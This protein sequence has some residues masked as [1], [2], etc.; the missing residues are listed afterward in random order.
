MKVKEYLAVD[1]AILADG[2]YGGV[3]GG[4]GSG[5]SILLKAYKIAGLEVAGLV[6]VEESDALKQQWT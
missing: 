1:G 5:G 6:H 2:G 4:G 3:K